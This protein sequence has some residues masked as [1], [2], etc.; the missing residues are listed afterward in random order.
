M[1]LATLCI[2]LAL[3]CLLLSC[4]TQRT[5]G[6]AQLTPTPSNQPAEVAPEEPAE[7][8]PASPA[9]PAP[10][11]SDTWTFK[12]KLE[13]VGDE[14]FDLPAW[15]PLDGF[16][17]TLLCEYPLTGEELKEWQDDWHEPDEKPIDIAEFKTR[18]DRHGRLTLVDSPS[19]LWQFED[20]APG[21]GTWS[22]K[23]ERYENPEHTKSG[24]LMGVSIL[25]V[26][27]ARDLKPTVA[28]PVC[29]FGVIQLDFDDLFPGRYFVAGRL[30]DSEGGPLC[31]S[32]FTSLIASVGENQHTF[33]FQTDADGRFMEEAYYENDEIPL[34][35]TD[36]A[37]WVHQYIYRLR[38]HEKHDALQNVDRP[39]LRGRILQFG[40][41][42]IPGG[43]LRV[44][45]KDNR[46]KSGPEHARWNKFVDDPEYAYFA[47]DC[48]SYLSS[49]NLDVP[50]DGSECA[51]WL[52]EGIYKYSMLGGDF[53]SYVEQG[54]AFTVPGSGVV[55]LEVPLDP[56]PVVAVELVPDGD[57]Q[58]SHAVASSWTIFEGGR[59]VRGDIGSGL[60]LAFPLTEGQH[61]EL[62]VEPGE[63]PGTRRLLYAGQSDIKIPLSKSLGGWIDV[64]YADP[65][66]GFALSDFDLQL[67]ISVGTDR[68]VIWLLNQP[69]QQDGL[70]RIEFTGD[71]RVSLRSKRD[72]GWNDWDS[73][74]GA[75]VTEPVEATIEAGKTVEVALPPL[76][77]PLWKHWA[78]KRGTKDFR[79]GTTRIPYLQGILGDANGAQKR[80][81]AGG[82]SGWG[83]RNYISLQDGPNLVALFEPPKSNGDVAESDVQLPVRLIL[84][85]KPMKDALG[86]PLY[87]ELKSSPDGFSGVQVDTYDSSVSLWAPPGTA[88]VAVSQRHGSTVLFHSIVELTADSVVEMT[89]SPQNADP[90]GVIVDIRVPEDKEERRYVWTFYPFAD[91]WDLY[92]VGENERLIEEGRVDESQTLGLLPGQYLAIH[93]RPS[94]PPFSFSVSD[95]AGQIIQFPALISTEY[96]T[97]RLTFPMPE[98]EYLLSNVRADP[99]RGGNPYLTSD[100]FMEHSWQ[101][102]GEWLTH[103]AVADGIKTFGFPLECETLVTGSIWLRRNGRTEVW[104]IRPTHLPAQLD[105]SV[106]AVELVRGIPLK[107]FWKDALII[108]EWLSGF[109]IRTVCGAL[110]PGTYTTQFD[111]W[112]NSEAIPFILTVEAGQEFATPPV[113]VVAQLDARYRER[114]GQEP[115]DD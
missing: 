56:L 85:L 11:A 36:A 9:E 102:Q 59:V 32:W 108:R 100:Y 76:F 112:G 22:L 78:S 113:E 97:V 98:G 109:A 35:T 8:E 88:E 58:Y 87:V 54:G 15:F 41:I 72:F 10:Q 80:G 45:V 66:E 63:Y 16:E 111:F 24:W 19:L 89:A 84:D 79:C 53:R 110:P 7:S 48:A 94:Q 50:Y 40:D 6:A 68:Q 83:G 38:E 106:T 46:P 49:P 42:Q 90:E 25:R 14:E 67:Q 21:A 92:R 29:D 23:V 114:S 75:A 18:F 60:E 43:V 55:R 61:A 74:N 70:C 86:G 27:V 103:R 77:T 93:T 64:K 37:S 57:L 31:R 71:V 44:R 47:I 26:I 52:P 20:T 28:R 4:S 2:T 107:G 51:I 99:V 17:A 1:R 65:P 5:R 62:V 12:G 13:L 81:G 73:Y 30:V 104:L 33:T 69:I 34:L 101:E 105:G 91:D 95:E 115:P 96:G 82:D 3:T 39:K